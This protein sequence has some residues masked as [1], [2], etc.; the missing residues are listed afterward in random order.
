MSLLISGKVIGLSAIR[1]GEPRFRGPCRACG[2][3]E[4]GDDGRGRNLPA[5]ASNRIGRACQL[6]ALDRQ[7]AGASR[8]VSL[9]ILVRRRL[10]LRSRYGPG[11]GAP[12][13]Q[14]PPRVAPIRR[15]SVA[16]RDSHDRIGGRRLGRRR[17]RHPTPPA[18]QTMI[19]PSAPRWPAARAWPTPWQC[20]RSTESCSGRC[21]SPAR[22]AR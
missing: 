16:G 17:L 12:S 3:N 7:K 1:G 11:G 21:L 18:H 13:V 10:R 8:A 15:L 4:P 9:R 6:R 5:A 2:A 14:Y 19:R 22:C 20:C